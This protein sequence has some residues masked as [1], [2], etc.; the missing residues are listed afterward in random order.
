MYLAIATV[1]HPDYFTEIV[2]LL[3]ATAL[4]A[5]A[6]HRIG[7]MPIVAF[8]VTG[9]LIG[10][11]ALGIVQNEALIEAA[12]EVGVILLLFT[13][14]IEFSLEKLARIKRIILIGGGLQVGLVVALVTGVLALFGVDWRT[15]VFTGCLVALS[16]TAIVMKLL[17]G[18]GDVATQEGQASLGILIFQDLAVVAM[19]LLVPMLG[20]AGASGWELGFALAKAAGI[21]A[22]VLVTA[23]R[24]MPWVLEAVA[25]TCSQEIFLLSVVA[26]CFGTAYLTSLAGISLSLG[27]FLAG[28]V[29]SESRFSQLAFAEILPL[30]ILFSAAFFVSVGLLFDPGFVLQNPLLILGIIAA[31][32]AIKVVATGVGLRVLG[33]GVGAAAGA[34]LLLAQIGEFSFVLERSGRGVG[35][36]PAGLQVGG[37][38]A[39]IAATVALMIATPFLYPLG[40]IIRRGS[41][42]RRE[43]RPAP[44]LQEADDRAADLRDHVI[45]AGLGDV[46]YALAEIVDE[47]RIP[48]V[49][50][51]LDPD[52][53]NDAEGNGLRVLRGNY[54]RQHELEHAGL[55]SAR[56][57]V[58]ADDDMETTRRVAEA[59][60]AL[61]PY[62][63]IFARTR[64]ASDVL[65]LRE[66]G[67]G[68]VVSEVQES[69][70]RLS[71][72]VLES[73]DV[74]AD[75]IRRY[76]DDLR[77]SGGIGSGQATFGDPV[78][79]SQAARRSDRCSHAGETREVFASAPG[80]EA[81]LSMGKRGWVHL[82]ICMSCGHVG[83]CGES[84]GD[85]AAKHFQSSGH[86]IVK[87]LEPGEAWAW[88]YED[89]TYI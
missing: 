45:I 7:I 85:H 34:S 2:A 79:L 29:V 24:I 64:L 19:V 54:T 69:A 5:F 83:C 82:R 88:C 6:C 81:C 55:R 22:L 41:R 46:G 33:Y 15:G 73:F 27:A 25:R 48:Y 52:R 42:R 40:E 28:L 84:P 13:I 71:T 32:F 36:Y 20:G 53:A 78:V 62:L 37:P 50:L 67:A 56:L 80:C 75:D 49:V 10:P 86:P 12:A 9:A 68:E 76:Q 11:H 39:F 26:I 23:R 47:R 63:P 30:Q 65:E 8:L 38:E 57:L 77:S 4:V 44:G 58:V 66:A 17:M 21:V 72:R 14:G 59:A 16:S 89:Q 35:L 51:T 60:R 3:V 18:G 74:S 43:D 70:I 87:S 1:V 61:N 31:V